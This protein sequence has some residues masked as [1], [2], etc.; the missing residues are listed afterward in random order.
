VVAEAQSVTWVPPGASARLVGE[1]LVL[2]L[3]G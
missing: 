2:E 3:P 1:H